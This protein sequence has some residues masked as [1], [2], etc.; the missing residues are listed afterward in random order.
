[1]TMADDA[2]ARVDRSK[3]LLAR[4]EAQK[5]G[6]GAGGGA[7][8]AAGG[9]FGGYSGAAAGG[10]GGGYG[11]AAGGGGGYG[12]ASLGGGGGGDG[13]G[14]YG[15]AAGLGG[16]AGALDGSYGGGLSGS[17]SM[18]GGGGGGMDFG[19]GGAG[20]GSYG[21]VH[22]STTD[23]FFLRAINWR[24]T[25]DELMQGWPEWL[26][27]RW[28]RVW[29]S[30]WW[31]WRVRGRVARRRRRCV[32]PE[33]S[34]DAQHDVRDAV[35]AHCATAVA[36]YMWCEIFCSDR[37]RV[38]VS[39]AVARWERY[40]TTI[41]TSASL[42]RPFD[43]SISG[44]GAACVLYHFSPFRAFAIYHL[45]FTMYHLGSFRPFRPI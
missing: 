6:G 11:A 14:A 36:I 37:Q 20:G 4:L 19:G 38:C 1:M 27:R 34:T 10:G 25:H 42:S 35:S 41:S 16:G 39:G 3:Q 2:A 23:S 43:L 13:G 22:Q 5:A 12:A 44:G 33:R 29:G 24:L 31:R 45:P 26:W 18:G 28:R 9:S 7:A 21:C 8:P 17:M 40:V 15:Q 32:R 30:R